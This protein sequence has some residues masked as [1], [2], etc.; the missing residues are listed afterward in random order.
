MRLPDELLLAYDR[1]VAEILTAVNKG[2]ADEDD[3]Q[4][5]ALAGY[6]PA[7]LIQEEFLKFAG[8]HPARVTEVL[9]D[10]ADVRHRIVAATVAGYLPDKKIAA[11]VL[12]RAALDVNEA[13]R[14]NAVR[15][16]GIIAR[17]AQLQGRRDI[18]IDPIPFIALLN[19]MTW[20]DRNKGMGLI[21]PLSA[22]RDPALLKLLD[23]NA[24]GSLRDMCRWK[25]WGHAAQ[26]C[27][28]LRRVRGLPEKWDE[29][30]REEALTA[31]A[32]ADGTE[33]P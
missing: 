6:P 7:R 23:E 14:N 26:A 28:V 32:G 30:S 27:V 5:H 17:Y 22:G 8:K 2:L 9:R 4:G 10:S 21:E 31:Q 15:A 18:S 33:P 19:S 24:G 11:A 3:S 1:Y 16:V 12:A 13:V 29:A 25:S 20:T